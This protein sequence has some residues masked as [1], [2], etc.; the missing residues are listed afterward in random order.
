MSHNKKDGRTVSIV[1]MSGGVMRRA[2]AYGVVCVA[3]M[4]AAVVAHANEAVPLIESGTRAGWLFDRT[5]G[6][7]SPPLYRHDFS[8]IPPSGRAVP[9]D[10]NAWRYTLRYAL[11][12]QPDSRFALGL[13]TRSRDPD[14]LMAARA[15]SLMRSGTAAFVPLLH[16]YGEHRLWGRLHLSGDLDAL[17][18]GRGKSYDLGLHMAYDLSR[19][20]SV[21][22]GYRLSDGGDDPDA[23]PR[24][25]AFSLGTQLR[26]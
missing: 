18:N 1:M 22:A 21:S 5:L 9:D 16:A 10:F 25:N 6:A 15:P 13:T 24:A 11:W 23:V 20:W 14:A 26:F 3:V 8:L 2:I 7:E 4:G 12:A 19:D 17:G